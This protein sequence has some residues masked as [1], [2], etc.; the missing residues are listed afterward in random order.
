MDQVLKLIFNLNLFVVVIVVLIII[1]VFFL[2]KNRIRR[3]KKR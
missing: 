3:I 1:F 2:I